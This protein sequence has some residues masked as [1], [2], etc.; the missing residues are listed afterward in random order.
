MVTSLLTSISIPGRTQ[1]QL[2]AGYFLVCVKRRLL[3]FQLS[4]W[5]QIRAIRPPFELSTCVTVYLACIAVMSS[6]ALDI[7]GESN[8]CVTEPGNLQSFSEL[9]IL[10]AM[11]V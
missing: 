8:L 6:A 4:H 5:W 9:P 1:S 2:A 10:E 3:I 7:D 11:V